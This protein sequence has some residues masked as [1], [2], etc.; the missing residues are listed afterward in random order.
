M[1]IS[2][3]VS[4]AASHRLHGH[5]GRCQFL[6]GHNYNVDIMLEGYSLDDVGRL[7]D[8]KAVKET[9]G[10]WIDAHWDHAFIFNIHDPIALKIVDLMMEEQQCG[11]TY[12]M[13]DNPTAEHMVRELEN[14]AINVLAPLVYTNE[15]LTGLHVKFRVWETESAYAESSEWVKIYNTE[16]AKLHAAD[17]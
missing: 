14:A 11:R 13:S 1:V 4:F 6:H 8:F 15:Q 3:R 10:E 7:M 5:E 9:I 12:G 2:K 16:Q 17:K